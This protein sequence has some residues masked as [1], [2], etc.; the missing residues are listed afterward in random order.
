M[1]DSGL[2]EMEKHYENR[3]LKEFPQRELPRLP[4]YKNELSQ[5][6]KENLFKEIYSNIAKFE[7]LFY[8]RKTGNNKIRQFS[9]VN[10]S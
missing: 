4:E 5:E 9:E 7:R 6:E 3:Q 8:G 2:G 1:I 10:L